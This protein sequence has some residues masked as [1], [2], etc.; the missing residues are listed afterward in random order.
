MAD[1]PFKS[2]GIDWD[3]IDSIL[4]ESG[5]V[6]LNLEEKNARETHASGTYKGID[7]LIK[8]MPVKGGKTTIGKATGRDNTYFDELANLIKDNCS[9]SE[10]KSYEYT[11]PEFTDKNK[12]HLFSFLESESVSINQDTKS[13]NPLCISEYVFEGGKGDKVRVKFYKRGSAQFQGRHLKVATLI[14]DFM[15]SIMNMEEI[16]EQKNKE[17]NVEIKK[18]A[19]N[20]ELH[21]KLPNSIDYVHEDI[22]KQISCSIIMKQIDVQMEDYSTYCFAALRALEGFIYQ[23]LGGVCNPSTARNLGE[24]FSEGAPRYTIR[25]IHKSI[26]NGEVSNVLC[27]CYT[28]WH[29]NRHSLFHMKPGVADTRVIEKEDSISI[30]D[31][32]CRLIDE[33][34]ARLRK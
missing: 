13:S 10:S 14:N 19:I 12:E 7:F 29:E 1:N 22:K 11:I 18:E 34:T 28:Y 6:N 30:I 24:Y 16:V 8:L 20:S 31:Q 33:G 9:Y 2:I 3:K 15:C 21:S 17:F 4:T 25:D 27:E 26:I 23:V 5:V 32:V